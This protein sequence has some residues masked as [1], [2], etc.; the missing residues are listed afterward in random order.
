MKG[1]F[2]V[3]KD[4]YKGK[5]LATYTKHSFPGVLMKWQWGRVRTEP[6]ALPNGSSQGQLP[7]VMVCFIRNQMI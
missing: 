3:G 7:V 5:E 1:N 6:E 4:G 2:P